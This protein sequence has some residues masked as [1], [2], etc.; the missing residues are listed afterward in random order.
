LW[1]SGKK[2]GGE[3]IHFADGTWLYVD[4]E[5]N[6]VPYVN[7]FPDF[8]AAGYVRQAVHIQMLGDQSD[9]KR[10]DSEAVRRAAAENGPGKIRP[11]STWHHHQDGITMQ[12][13]PRLINNRFT[14]RGGASAS[15]KSK[16]K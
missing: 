9:F 10:A 6:A 13:V 12:E 5:G 8:E 1:K 11:D 4:W 14:H 16:S 3:V 7:G 15:R 2:R